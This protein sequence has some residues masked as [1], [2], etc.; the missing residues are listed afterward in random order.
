MLYTP[1]NSSPCQTWSGNECLFFHTEGNRWATSGRAT[2]ANET[3][4]IRPCEACVWETLVEWL[5]LMG[6][7]TIWESEKAPRKSPSATHITKKGHM[8]YNSIPLQ[9]VGGGWHSVPGWRGLSNQQGGY[10]KWERWGSHMHW[11]AKIPVAQRGMVRG[12]T[13]IHPLCSF[14]NTEYIFTAVWCA[15]VQDGVEVSIYGCY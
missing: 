13:H 6:N 11:V 3:A 9:G 1:K 14:H 7:I 15:T 4:M 5:I 8:R 10:G 12:S 2:E